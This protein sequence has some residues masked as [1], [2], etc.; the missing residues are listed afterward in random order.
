MEK[1]RKHQ[2]D[3]WWQ[4]YMEVR[5]IRKENGIDKTRKGQEERKVK[6]GDAQNNERS[7]KKERNRGEN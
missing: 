1:Q 2:L 6:H 7:E 3:K 4:I 5:E